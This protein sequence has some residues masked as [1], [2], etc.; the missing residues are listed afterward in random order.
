MILSNTYVRITNN[1]LHDMATGTWAA[2]L[3]V[4]WVLAGRIF[5]MGPEATGA[6]RDSMALVFW[7]LVAALVIVSVTGA[8]RLV[9]WRT[10]TPAHELSA[11]RRAL[12]IKHIVFLVVYGGGTLWAWALAF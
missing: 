9:Y 5:G 4:L 3:L 8:F 1:F 6:L 2:C 11:K 7:M 10:T 12:V